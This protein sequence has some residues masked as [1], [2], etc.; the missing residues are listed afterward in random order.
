MLIPPSHTR[1][2]NP[3]DLNGSHPTLTVAQ[4]LKCIKEEEM[5]LYKF[6]EKKSGC[7][8]WQLEL[9][10]HLEARGLLAKDTHAN[11]Y[12][13]IKTYHKSRQGDWLKVTFP[14]V[15]GKF[16]KGL[17]EVCISFLYSIILATLCRKWTT[18]LAY[19]LLMNIRQAACDDNLAWRDFGGW[20]VQ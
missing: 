8:C 10:K 2:H 9:V 19:C 7:M 12:A 3:A 18:A 1:Q 4:L 17:G 15:P 20:L 14:P 5:Y 13:I 16:G 11:L 6:N